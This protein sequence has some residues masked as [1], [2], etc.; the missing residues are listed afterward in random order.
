MKA[1]KAQGAKVVS[2]N[3]K[4]EDAEKWTKKVEELED[5][6]QEEM[7]NE[8]EEKQ[9][10]TADMEV[11]KAENLIKHE[12]EIKARPKRTWFAKRERKEDMKKTKK[13]KKGG[14]AGKA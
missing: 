9:L 13:P 4:P 5:Q 11:N 2:R 12:K 1:G 10:A 6:I 7:R 3:V 8:K 14:K